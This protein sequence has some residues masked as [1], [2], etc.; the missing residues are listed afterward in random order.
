MKGDRIRSMPIHGFVSRIIND[1]P[2]HMMQACHPRHRYTYRVAELALVLEDDDVVT[3]IFLS[4][5]GHAV[6]LIR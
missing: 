1:L 4:R 6:N 2:N 5:G 3:L